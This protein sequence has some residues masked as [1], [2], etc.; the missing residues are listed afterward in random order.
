MKPK[1][2][3]KKLF[4]N[5]KTIAH[6]NNGQLGKAKGGG[7]TTSCDTCETCQT[8]CSCTCET[9]VWTV[10]GCYCTGHKTC[11]TY[12]CPVS[13]TCPVFCM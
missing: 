9:C 11:D 12:L 1:K 7:D 2:I 4:L 10:T 8:N 5:K 13:D 6:L 3:E